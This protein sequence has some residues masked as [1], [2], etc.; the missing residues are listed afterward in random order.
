[1]QCKSCGYRLWNLTSRQCPECGTRFLPSEFEFVPNSVQF[2]C[3]HCG[4]A[5]YGTG[6]KGHLVPA[7]FD[8]A[9]CARHVHMDE[10]V[11]L[12]TV[13]VAEEQTQVERMPWLER[14]E[15]GRWRAWRSTIGQALI[16]PV[17]LMKMT[18]VESPAG[19]AWRFAVLTSF[20]PLLG[21]APFVAFAIIPLL[22]IGL[23]GGPRPFG[24]WLGVGSFAMVA[25][26]AVGC[27]IA[28]MIGIALWGA[29][30]HG[31]LLVTGGT[32]AGIGRTYQALCYSSGAN[33]IT[34]VPC[35]GL[36]IGWLWWLV[37]AI[38]MVREGQRV[39]GARATF[40]VLFL[41]AASLVGLVGLTWAVASP[42]IAAIGPFS[43]TM[44]VGGVPQT[45]SKSHLTL[46]NSKL[47]LY[48]TR[49]GGRG[50]GHAIEALDDGPIIS[51]LFGYGSSTPQDKIPIGNTT[52]DRYVLLP[53]D[54]QR[55][56]AQPA[57]AKL[58]KG[59]IAH[60]LGDYVFT[61]HGINL[62]RPADPKLWVVILSP[63]RA[64]GTAAPQSVFVSLAGGAADTV[65][66]PADEFGSRLAKQNELR[67]KYKL[68]PLPDPNTVTHASPAV[69]PGL[70]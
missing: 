62:M 27:V 39:H 56:V 1:V 54:Q 8:C 36:Y 2:C 35:L 4:Q 25:L 26:V 57:A 67:A 55:Q 16:G 30:A 50:P 46:W 42:Q 51:I 37:S 63:E 11:I 44:P 59:T 70:R 31:L 17:R 64:G 22:I 19:E 13:G 12:P 68:P 34:A 69:A 33:V 15:R 7:E 28:T 24:P 14:K 53:P 5:Y 6:P 48:A 9:S 23:P 65:A 38:L 21:L 45:L 40:A 32:R 66:I 10:M 43:T 3:P 47:L 18:P 29:L 61:Y 20:V 52:L 58:P 41:P 60:R 49:N